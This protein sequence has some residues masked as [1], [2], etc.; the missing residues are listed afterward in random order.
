MN[1]PS[2]SLENLHRATATAEMSTQ[3][4]FD[5]AV[6]WVRI[7]LQS[8]LARQNHRGRAVAALTSTPREK[9]L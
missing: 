5:L 3:G 1:N 7:L 9:S 8:C 2:H 4:L 6:G